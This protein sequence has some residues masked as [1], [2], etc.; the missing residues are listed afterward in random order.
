MK[1]VV[2][3][4]AFGVENVKVVEHPDPEPGPGQVVLRMKAASLNYRDLLMVRGQYDPR[5]TLPIVPLSDGVGVVEAVGP[6]VDRVEVGARVCPIFAQRWI[7]GR[8]TRS[9]IRSTL[10]GPL[11]GTLQEKMVV[12]AE[13]V[14]VLP[15]HLSD[16]EA[17]TLPCAALTAWSALS[18]LRATE[19]GESVVVQ[20]TGGVS[21]FALCF[22]KRMGARVIATSSNDEK[23]ERAKALGADAVIN[24]RK[25]E[26]WGGTAKKM[27]GGEGVDHVVDVGGGKTLAQSVRA[28]RPGGAISVIGVLAGVASD[29]N[30]LPILM[31]QLRLQGVLV[32]HREGFEAMLRAIETWKLSPK[33]LG[34]VDR[35]FPM[36]DAP[37]ALEHLGSGEHFG[38]VCLEV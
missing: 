34:L 20:G 6:G 27:A 13:G 15:S 19:P 31:Q 38:K 24:Y 2:I 10:G 33:E 35:V 25:D 11:D 12:D 28:V 8:P 23:L 29:L 16:V 3:D 36:K 26:K 37:A 7:S 21:L 22:A 18:T 9:R 4:G 17:A 32:G 30:L 5:Q 14:V 1:A